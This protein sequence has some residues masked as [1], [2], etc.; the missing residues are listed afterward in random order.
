M[1][2]LKLKELLEKNNV[3]FEFKSKHMDGDNQKVVYELYYP[4]SESKFT[5][6]ICR[7]ING[8][9][10]GVTDRLEL[11]QIYRDEKRTRNILIIDLNAEQVFFRIRR[12]QKNNKGG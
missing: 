3:P 8:L 10:S 11:L 2:I 12:R 1:E 5:Q 4:S 7:Q 9:I 6:M